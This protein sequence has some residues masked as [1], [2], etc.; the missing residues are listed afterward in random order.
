MSEDPKDVSPHEEWMDA[1]DRQYIT[2][3]DALDGLF[4]EVVLKRVKMTTRQGSSSDHP[5]E[6]VVVEGVVVGVGID[7]LVSMENPGRRTG[8]MSL[9][10]DNG[11]AYHLKPGMT[12]EAWNVGQGGDQ[13][14]YWEKVLEALP[15]T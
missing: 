8:R 1:W 15:N 13:V 3:E 11:H 2:N 6:V 4:E 10:L 14:G 12:V 5:D 9:V 7:I